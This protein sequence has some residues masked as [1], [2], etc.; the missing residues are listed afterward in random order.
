MRLFFIIIQ[1]VKC[2]PSFKEG[3]MTRSLSSIETSFWMKFRG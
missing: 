2:A 3:E 1:V